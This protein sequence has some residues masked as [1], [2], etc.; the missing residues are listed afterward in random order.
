MRSPVEFMCQNSGLQVTFQWPSVDFASCISQRGF[1]FDKVQS[2]S[3]GTT[4]VLAIILATRLTLCISQGVAQPDQ[5]LVSK[6]PFETS[7]KPTCQAQL[8]LCILC[9]HDFGTWA[10]K[11]RRFPQD[12][13]VFSC[14]KLTTRKTSADEPQS[15]FLILIKT[16]W[17]GC[18]FHG[19]SNLH[20]F[21]R[22]CGGIYVWSGGAKGRA[23]PY[24]PG[25]GIE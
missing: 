16:G 9:K 2:S 19:G 6:L 23:G 11:A 21:V 17:N 8:A 1:E 15:T 18:V 24:G 25:G 5:L 10:W 13:A 3:H 14:A 22:T 20:A 12:P 4:L 7:V